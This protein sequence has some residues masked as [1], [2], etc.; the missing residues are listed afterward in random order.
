MGSNVP[1]KLAKSVCAAAHTCVL[2]QHRKQRVALHVQ[3]LRLGQ[4]LQRVHMHGVLHR[5]QLRDTGWVCEVAGAAGWHVR[6]ST[7][8]KHGTQETLDKHAARRPDQPGALQLRRQC[9]R[10]SG[11]TAREGTQ[12][13]L[14]L[15]L[16]PLLL[17]L[18]VPLTTRPPV[19]RAGDRAAY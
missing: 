18:L 10:S 5:H 3:L 15:S 8:A 1:D 9:V 4:E 17:V 2:V 13:P 7:P 19:P 11:V 12:H 6:Q 14:L 16:P